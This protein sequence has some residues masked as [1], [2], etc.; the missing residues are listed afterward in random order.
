M[1]VRKGVTAVAASLSLALAGQGGAAGA[2]SVYTVGSTAVPGVDTGMVLKNGLSATVTATGAVCPWGTSVCVGPNGDSSFNTSASGFLLPGAAAWGLVG[3]V[4][5]GP[6]VQVGSGPT[7]L[8]GSGALVFAV[9]DNYYPDITGSFMV[10]VSV[11]NACYPGHGYGDTNHEHCGPPG[12]DPTACYP[13]HGSGDANREH[14]GPPGQGSGTV[15]A[16]EN[17]SPGRGGGKGRP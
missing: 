9:N 1:N 12:Q 2:A 16:T 11:G 14:C 17:G 3:R 5:S 6:W 8:S 7:K 15:D 10:T 13:G 4:G